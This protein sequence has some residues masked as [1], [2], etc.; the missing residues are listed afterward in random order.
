MNFKEIFK[1]ELQYRS[2]R[3]A[4]YIYFLILFA[5]SIALAAMGTKGFGDLS[6]QVKANAPLLIDRQ[7]G[8]LTMPMM[9]LVSAI[10]GVAVIRDYEHRMEQ[11]LFSTPI[12]KLDYLLGRF[13]GSFVV[14]ILVSMAIPLGSILGEI[15]SSKPASEMLALSP[16]NHVRAFFYI[17]VPNTFFLSALFFSSGV[18]TKKMAVIYTQGIVLLIFFALL[19]E[20]AIEVAKNQKLSTLFDFFMVQLLNLKAQFWSAAEINESTIPIDGAILINRGIYVGTGVLAL[21]YAY[22]RFNFSI[23]S[24]QKKVKSHDA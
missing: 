21:V 5:L 3:P 8:I 17:V 14:M 23:N 20:G 16:W 12:T 4:N 11:L 1:F 13:F 9:L 6:V 19:D 18:L 24:I 7:M 15:V 10:M 22:F 2:R